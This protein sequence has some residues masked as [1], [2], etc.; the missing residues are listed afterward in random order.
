MQRSYCKSPLRGTEVLRHSQTDASPSVSNIHNPSLSHSPHWSPFDFT[1]WSLAGH[2]GVFWAHW[3][4]SVVHEW[5]KNRKWGSSPAVSCAVNSQQLCW[6]IQQ[7]HWTPV[8]HL[9]LRPLKSCPPSMAVH[10]LLR[11]KQ[12]FSYPLFT[13]R[14]QVSPQTATLCYTVPP[15]PHYFLSCCSPWFPHSLASHSALLTLCLPN[16]AMQESRNYKTR[17]LQLKALESEWKG[18]SIIISSPV[19]LML[20]RCNVHHDHSLTLACLHLLTGTEHKGN[21][22]SFAGIRS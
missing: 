13:T 20:S 14:P 1:V 3:L 15:R 9:H 11:K 17:S 16:S 12:T 19:K 4:F 5:R 2:L 18:A 7:K 8:P 22:I 10:S 21:V 6:I